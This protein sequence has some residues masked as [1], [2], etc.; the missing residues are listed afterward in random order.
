[1]VTIQIFSINAT[2]L[3]NSAANDENIGDFIRISSHRSH[4]KLENV[5][6]V[7]LSKSNPNLLPESQGYSFKGDVGL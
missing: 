2:N 5:M 6:G 7:F 3:K 1:M 4:L